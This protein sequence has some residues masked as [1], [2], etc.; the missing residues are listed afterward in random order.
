MDQTIIKAAE[1]VKD[2]RKRLQKVGIEIVTIGQ[3]KGYIYIYIKNRSMI[4]MIDKYLLD[5]EKEVVLYEKS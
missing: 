2:I 5:D 1:M 3:C 4:S